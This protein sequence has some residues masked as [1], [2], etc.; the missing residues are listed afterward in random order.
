MYELETREDVK[1]FVDEYILTAAEV[2]ELLNITRSR[3]NQL[4]K[5]ERLI[6]LKQVTIVSLFWK[7]DVEKL[8]EELTVL[9]KKYYR[10]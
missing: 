4:V 9:R 8:G 1:Q 7:P 10:E 6:P 2:L 5:T 3:L